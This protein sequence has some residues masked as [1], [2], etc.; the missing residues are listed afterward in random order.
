MTAL[1]FIQAH[2]P[3]DP[4]IR[5]RYRDYQNKVMALIANHGGRLLATG[6]NLETFE[7]SAPVRRVIVLEFP[8]IKALRA[9]W[10]S[11]EYAQIR[12]LRDGCEVSAW[13]IPT[14]SATPA[15]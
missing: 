14:Q 6:Q 11:P 1:F 5:R 8:E 12:R 4:D 15:A 7:G 13:A 3:D 10:T 2:V 9:F